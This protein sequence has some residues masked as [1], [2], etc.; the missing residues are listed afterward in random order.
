MEDLHVLIQ[1]CLA[2]TWEQFCT[3]KRDVITASFRKVVL[4]L[5][6]DGSCDS[7][8]SI[9]GLNNELLTIGNWRLD[10]RNREDSSMIGQSRSF[11]IQDTGN[12]ATE[13]VEEDM[14]EDINLDEADET[15]LI[16]RS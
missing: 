1:K 11:D 2:N 16:N 5:P 7:E 8:L 10:K 4:A 12:E 9:K 15:D 3:T 14:E 13:G 6:I